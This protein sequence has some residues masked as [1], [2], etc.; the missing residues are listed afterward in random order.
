MSFTELVLPYLPALW[1][2]FLMTLWLSAAVILVATPLALLI[3][4]M[5]DSQRLWLR[6]PATAYVTV[7]RMVPALI[8]AVLDGLPL[9]VQYRGER[10]AAARRGRR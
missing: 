4:L 8:Y 7:F 1:N 3:A 5:R 9:L 6:L 10:W 2:G